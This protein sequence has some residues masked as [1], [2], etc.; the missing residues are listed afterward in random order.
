MSLAFNP[1]MFFEHDDIDI[2]YIMHPDEIDSPA[3]PLEIREY[4]L[5]ILHHFVFPGVDVPIETRSTP[6]VILAMRRCYYEG[7]FEASLSFNSIL[8]SLD[9]TNRFHL[10]PLQ[11][12][13]LMRLKVDVTVW[14]PGYCN[15]PLTGMHSLGLEFVRCK[16]RIFPCMIYTLP[17]KHSRGKSTVL[18][19][20]R[21]LD[22]AGRPGGMIICREDIDPAQGYRLVVESNK[23]PL[24]W[25]ACNCYGCTDMI[26]PDSVLGRGIETLAGSPGY[27]QFLQ[28]RRKV[29]CKALPCYD[30]TTQSLSERACEITLSSATPDSWRSA[31][32]TLI[33]HSLVNMGVTV[34]PGY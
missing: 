19:C 20:T 30:N 26:D 15:S 14:R 4:L 25:G 33:Q 1:D 22:L 10:T 17:V 9:C 12:G 27:R 32:F 23:R 2:A 34:F 3:L 24:I 29:G 13:E 6:Q 11:E 31:G 21:H 18:N 5:Y 16:S 28:L 7:M 8:L